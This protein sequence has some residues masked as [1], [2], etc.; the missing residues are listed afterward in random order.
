[1]DTAQAGRSE[2]YKMQTT[3][4]LPKTLSSNQAAGLVI[5]IIGA[6]TTS[7]FIT[8]L[9]ITPPI[10]YILGAAIQWILTK[11]ETP[12]WRN[13]SYPM[14]GLIAMTFDVLMNAVGIWPYVRDQFGNTDL[15]RMLA[16]LTQNSNP[17]TLLM[18]FAIAVIIGVAVAAGP[19]YFFSRKD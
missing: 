11:A 10:S 17:P 19:E 14:I 13:Q 1:M 7:L 9:G 16:D 3:L 15:W 12:I 2:K 18:R 8:Q 5:W 4:R 6:F